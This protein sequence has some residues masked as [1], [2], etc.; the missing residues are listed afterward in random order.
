[1]SR[2]GEGPSLFEP[3]EIW[4]PTVELTRQPL[5]THTQPG[6]GRNNS[7]RPT[8]IIADPAEPSL[9]AFA[10]KMHFCCK[11]LLVSSKKIKA[12]SQ[13]EPV[14]L[15]LFQTCSTLVP[16]RTQSTCLRGT[17]ASH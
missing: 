2:A 13:F 12:G 14:A 9:S 8:G 15:K 16:A 10:N 3:P 11:V 6:N 4:S 5:Q 7:G 17:G 1:M